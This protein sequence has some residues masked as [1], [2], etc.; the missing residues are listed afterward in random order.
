MPNC[1]C[2]CSPHIPSSDWI[3][4]PTFVISLSW[5]ISLHGR[6]MYAPLWAASRPLYALLCS[7]FH[8]W[9]VCNTKV[10][11][12]L[13]IITIQ[14]QLRAFRDWLG[15]GLGILHVRGIYEN[16][17]SRGISSLFFF[18][19]DGCAKCPSKSFLLGK[20]LSCTDTDTR[21]GIGRI[22]IRGY[23]NFPK[24]PIRGYV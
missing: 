22:R 1:C 24:K 11:A 14:I 9:V 3:N 4:C 20:K 13:G 19:F 17:L 10:C 15:L 18:S 12:Q 23:A 7:G 6:P 21:I 16:L 2:A 8:V 5:S